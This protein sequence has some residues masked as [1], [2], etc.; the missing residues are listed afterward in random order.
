MHDRDDN[1]V[2]IYHAGL[3]T[4]LCKHRMCRSVKHPM[5]AKVH[6][7][8]VA[9]PRA[10]ALA[11]PTDG[12]WKGRVWRTITNTEFDAAIFSLAVPALGSLIIEPGVRLEHPAVWLACELR[13]SNWW[14][15]LLKN[16][17]MVLA[18]NLGS[19]HGGKI[20]RS[21]SGRSQHWR[22]RCVGIVSP[23]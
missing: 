6:V 9:W 3:S 22:I 19:D 18:Q 4:L 11:P 7:F 23:F 16:S 12:G 10:H 15:R 14:P 20:R 21:T 17:H 13:E 8:H 1:N 5:H 2:L